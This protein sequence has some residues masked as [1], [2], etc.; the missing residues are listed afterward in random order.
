MIMA[1]YGINHDG[2]RSTLVPYKMKRTELELHKNG[3][4]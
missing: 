2:T 4:P 1:Q 3:I